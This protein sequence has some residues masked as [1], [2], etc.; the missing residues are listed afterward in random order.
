MIKEVKF[1]LERCAGQHLDSNDGD[2][3]REGI[4]E[5]KQRLFNLQMERLSNH[6]NEKG[7]LDKMPKEEEDLQRE[8]T[9]LTVRINKFLYA[10]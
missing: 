6:I 4:A 3:L 8:I 2:A 5:I 7:K 1:L 9:G 10:D